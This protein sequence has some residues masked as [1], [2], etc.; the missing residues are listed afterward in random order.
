LWIPNPN[1]KVWFAQLFTVRNRSARSETIRN[2]F[3]RSV[4]RLLRH[5]LAGK[6]RDL[7]DLL[8]HAFW[9]FSGAGSLRAEIRYSPVSAFRLHGFFRLCTANH[10]LERLE[11]ASNAFLRIGTIRHGFA[12]GFSGGNWFAPGVR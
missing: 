12:R 2:G 7:P 3:A 9:A 10:D 8:R 4:R 5:A 11:S 1:S 6:R